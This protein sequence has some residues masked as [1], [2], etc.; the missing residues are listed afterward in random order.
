MSY[1]IP[2]P[3]EASKGF[4]YLTER[5]IKPKSALFHGARWTINRLTMAKRLGTN[6]QFSRQEHDD[7]FFTEL[8][9]EWSKESG[10][11]K[12]QYDR[13]K[14]DWKP[15]VWVPGAGEMLSFPIHGGGGSLNKSFFDID[16]GR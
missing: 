15:L 3:P 5:G 4:Q 1:G 6:G 11:S 13:M 2:V 7:Y 12:V 16:G 9:P 8:F 14:R 10:M